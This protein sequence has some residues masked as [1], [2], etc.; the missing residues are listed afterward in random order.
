MT[1]K[2]LENLLVADY[3]HLKRV[4]VRA[5]LDTMINEMEAAL[6]QGITVKLHR[7]GKLF[8]HKKQLPGMTWLTPEQHAKGTTTVKF[9]PSPLLEGRVNND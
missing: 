2:D 4:V 7:F 3:P 6:Q 5:A 1:R 8:K 9:V